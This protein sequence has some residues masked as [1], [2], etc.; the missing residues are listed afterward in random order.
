MVGLE[1]SLEPKK[2]HGMSSDGGYAIIDDYNLPGA[3]RATD[4]HRASN[5]IQE[6]IQRIDWTGVYWRKSL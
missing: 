6:P 4:D 5:G 1:G 2:S 3:R